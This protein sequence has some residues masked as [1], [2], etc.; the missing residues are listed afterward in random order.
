VSDRQVKLTRPAAADAGAI[1]SLVY[2]AKRPVVMGI[3]FAAVRDLVSFLRHDAKDAQG[4]A[5]PVAD[6]K[7][8]TAIGA[9]FSLSGRFL[10][11]FLWQGFNDDARGHKVFDGLYPQVAGAR[12]TF[13]NFRF[14]QPGRF[15]RQHEDHF[16]PGD[17]FPFAYAVTTDP[18]TGRTDG[19]LAKCSAT[20]TCPKVINVDGSFEFWQGRAAL[21]VTDGAGNDIGVPDNVRHY[22]VPGTSHGGGSGWGTALALPQCRNATS[23]VR[24]NAVLRAGVKLLENW[25]VAGTPPPASNMGSIAGGTLVT[26][27]NG[28]LNTLAVT[29]YTDAI[30]VADPSRRY[31]VRVPATDEDGNERTGVRVPEVAAPLAMY[32]GWN[33][34]NAGFAPGEA[35]SLFGSQLPFTADVL[36]ARYAGK[37]DF[38]TRVRAAAQALV[39]QGFLLDGDV[40]G[41][42]AQAA[43]VTVLP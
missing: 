32:T 23:P 7:F 6:L 16:Q 21:G 1:Y 5:N 43:T 36:Q 15:S 38:A 10:R 22:Y 2:T 37:A 39:T 28:A 17:Q 20:D 9:G 35:C 24:E 40:E 8:D 3:G 13:T 29:D 26:T 18:V 34:R 27:T 41:Y 11:D 4:N 31:E 33:V 42:A 19:L 25:L 30:A 12:R 14:G